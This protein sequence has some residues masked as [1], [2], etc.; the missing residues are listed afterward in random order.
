MF[1]GKKFK[2]HCGLTNPFDKGIIFYL[3]LSMEYAFISGKYLNPKFDTKVVDAKSLL[4]LKNKNI[5][6]MTQKAYKNLYVLFDM[7]ADSQNV[8]MLEMI[9]LSGVHLTDGTIAQLGRVL[10]NGNVKYLNLNRAHITK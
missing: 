3:D 2:K 1:D 5:E 10:K 9:N 7:L 4:Q 8:K 6:I